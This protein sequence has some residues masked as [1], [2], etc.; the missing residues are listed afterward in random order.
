MAWSGASILEQAKNL[1][2]WFIDFNLP[3]CLAPSPC[4]LA[5]LPS[6][7]ALPH[8]A[9]DLLLEKLLLLQFRHDQSICARDYRVGGNAVVAKNFENEHKLFCAQKQTNRAVEILISDLTDSI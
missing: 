9:S 4:F 8:P 7:M 1:A 5:M 3:V 6:S 2:I